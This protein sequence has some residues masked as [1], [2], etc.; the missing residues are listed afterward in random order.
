MILLKVYY[1]LVCWMKIFIYKMIYGKRLTMPMN[2]SFR[3]GFHL[4]IESSG[5]VYIGN[6]CTIRNSIILNDV[7]IGDNTYIENCIVESHGTIRANSNYVGEKDN[8]KIVQE[9]NERYVL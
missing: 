3:S 4:V 7:Y 8:I 1:H 2:C 6:N 9:K 5:E